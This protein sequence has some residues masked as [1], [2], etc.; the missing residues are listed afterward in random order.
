MYDGYCAPTG[1]G[2]DTLDNDGPFVVNEN[3]ETFNAAQKA[4]EFIEMV[5]EVSLHYRTNH[6][7]I[8]MG[9]D[10]QFSNAH[11]NF[12][13]LDR[14]I[15]YI[16]ERYPNVTLM[17]STPGNYLD[18]LIEANV[19]W[20]VK[21]DDMFPYSD[22]PGDFWTGYFTSRANSKKQVRDGQANIV[23]SNKLYAAKMIDQ[24]SS[25]EEI[26]KVL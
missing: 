7:L 3:L 11:L 9:C 21:Y 24:K 23:A 20:P 6:I 26:E 12:V 25:D 4:R 19:S 14:M 16:N 2:F 8:P 15:K 10:F 22:G 1:F 13:S 17:Y 18:K 5:N